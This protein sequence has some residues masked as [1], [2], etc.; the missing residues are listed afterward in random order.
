MASWIVQAEESESRR[1]YTPFEGQG[2]GDLSD[3]ASTVSALIKK[4]SGWQMLPD[5]GTDPCVFYIG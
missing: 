5:K 1:G 4:H 2:L 3:N